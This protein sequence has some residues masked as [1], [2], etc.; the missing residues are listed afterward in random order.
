VFGAGFFRMTAIDRNDKIFSKKFSAPSTLLPPKRENLFIIIR[1]KSFCS[2]FYGGVKNYF[3]KIVKKSIFHEN[4]LTF[5][6]I[7]INGE[8]RY[9]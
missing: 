8:V 2:G 3:G 5:T 6:A 4:T 7:S 1:A 9:L